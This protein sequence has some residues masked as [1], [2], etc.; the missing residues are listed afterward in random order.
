MKRALAYWISFFAVLFTFSTVLHAEPE[1]LILDKNHTYVLW[2]I[3][4]L[5]FSTQSGK[6]YASGELVLDKDHPEKSK[7]NV[8]I[9]LA[10]IVTGL[11]E[12]DKHL[13]SK[14]FFDVDHY[15]QATFVSDK[16]TVLSKNTAKVSGI[17]TLRGI[18][19]PVDL[20]VTFNKA[21]VNPISDKMTVGFSAKGAIKR[22]DFGMNSLL[23]ALGDEVNLSIDAEAYQDKK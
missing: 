23:P 4:H 15:P 3:Q 14:L 12:L 19:K 7:V 16:V 17:L 1:T 21:G 22:S 18:S 9:N 11:P 8:S 6:W 5:G 2:N 10:D 13:K 20:Q